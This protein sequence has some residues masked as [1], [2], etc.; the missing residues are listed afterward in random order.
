M[1][2]NETYRFSSFMIYAET[3]CEKLI[4]NEV[5]LFKQI[6]AKCVMKFYD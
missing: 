4:L 5:I 2:I 6:H 1:K 3:T